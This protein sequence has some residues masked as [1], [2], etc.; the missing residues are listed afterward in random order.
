MEIIVRT[1]GFYF[2]GNDKTF[3]KQ[4]WQEIGAKEFDK[5]GEPDF[6]VQNALKQEF[7]VLDLE[8]LCNRRIVSS[9]I[10]GP[11]GW[12]NWNGMIFCNN[13]NIG[14]WPSAIEV[15]NEWKVI[16]KAF[17]YL[18]LRCQLFNAECSE[19]REPGDDRPIEAVVEYTVKN[20]KVRCGT[21]K[22]EICPRAG[23]DNTSVL[24]SVMS[25]VAGNN[26]G[27]RGCTIETLKAALD[28]VK[29]VVGSKNKIKE[30]DSV[31]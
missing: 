12:C 23:F 29:R 18:S 31:I 20:G 15:L 16:A 25:L 28:A 3:S 4:I 22:G 27:E 1:S 24:A 9:W 30:A 8:Y 7:G 11:H 14:K 2:G 10:G 21:P 5:W 6:Q 17:P 13:Y 26:M 19:E